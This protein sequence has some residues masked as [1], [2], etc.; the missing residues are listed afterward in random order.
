[1]TLGYRVSYGSSNRLNLVLKHTADCDSDEVRLNGGTKCYQAPVSR[2]NSNIPKELH[3]QLAKFSKKA[4]VFAAGIIFLELI[5]LS[6]PSTLYKDMWPHILHISLPPALKEIL[7][8]S[9]AADPETRTGSFDELL[10]ILRSDE[11]KI[12]GE[13]SEDVDLSI[14]ISSGVEV[15]LPSVLETDQRSFSVIRKE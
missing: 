6:S 7:K 11:G 5:T 12:I 8:M 15:L 10:L 4:D 13:L 9:L 1:V 3:L 2:S 14:D